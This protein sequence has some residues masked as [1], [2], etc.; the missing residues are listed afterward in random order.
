[1]VILKSDCTDLGFET[2]KL[3]SIIILLNFLFSALVSSQNSV[4]FRKGV[5]IDS[6]VC[7]SN[8]R[9]TYALYLP[10]QYRP[11]TAWPIIY[12]F[13]P[14]ARGAL[15]VQLLVKAAEKYGYIVVGSNNSRNGPFQ[16]QFDAANALSTDTNVRFKIDQKR[17]YTLGFSG[18]GRLASTIAVL[19]SRIAGVIACGA[20]FS[21]DYFPPLEK[22]FVYLGL[23][24]TGD[25]NYTEMHATA[26]KLD[27]LNY[28]NKILIFDGGHQWPSEELF[29]EAVE[30]LE[31]QAMQRG[32]KPRDPKWVEDLFTKA[33]TNAKQFE[34]S[35]QLFEAY[36][37]YSAI[38]TDFTDLQDLQEVQNKVARL[39]DSKPVK[40][41]LK[42]EKQLELRELKYLKKFFAAFQALD[43]EAYTR[44]GDLEEHAWWEKEVRAL[45]EKSEKAKTT[46]EKRM[47]SRIIDWLWRHCAEQS[48]V[49]FEEN[50]LVKAKMYIDIWNIV[51]PD[52]PYPKYGLARVY[53]LNGNVAKAL[54]ALNTAVTL[55]F[56]NVPLLETDE[57]L[58]SLRQEEAFKKLVAE[59]KK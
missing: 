1:L 16:Q 5:V 35:E 59:L 27:R 47:L 53:A 54:E 40:A 20:S 42:T 9:Q 36:K 22:N 17:M 3:F 51:L 12:A 44:T 55:G 21:Y 8:A 6:V 45:N 34:G 2:V 46:E 37:A 58:D 11:D 56:D 41:A 50:G 25:M 19:T 49:F 13:D 30:W 14:V 28:P 48:S 33:L 52:K 4:G 38:L 29:M 57:Y 26:R 18:G 10:S 15:P 7:R 24:G 39:Q 32:H 31:L 43:V 23:I